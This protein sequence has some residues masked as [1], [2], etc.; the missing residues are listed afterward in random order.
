MRQPLFPTFARVKGVNL[1][2]AALI[3]PQQRP[4]L[5]QLATVVQK[6][7]AMHLSA[8]TNNR[9]LRCRFS[10]AVKHLAYTVAGGL[11]P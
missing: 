2:L 1:R 9:N 11:P 6:D 5:H 7:G 4:I 3:I 8:S 10:I